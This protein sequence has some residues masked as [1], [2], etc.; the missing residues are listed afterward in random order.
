MAFGQ[1]IIDYKN[2]RG[3]FKIRREA[4]LSDSVGRVKIK[5]TRASASGKF[6]YGRTGQAGQHRGGKKINKERSSSHN[7]NRI[8]RR[9]VIADRPIIMATERRFGI[10]PYIRFSYC[11]VLENKFLYIFHNITDFYFFCIYYFFLFIFFMW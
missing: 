7:K 4:T 10:S 6:I 11:F 2:T 8:K 1:Y 5:F 3:I 9:P